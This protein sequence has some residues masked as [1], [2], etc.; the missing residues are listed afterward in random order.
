MFLVHSDELPPDLVA[1][2]SLRDLAP[3]ELL[4]RRGDPAQAVYAVLHGL[5]QLFSCTTEGKQVPLYVAR[6]GECVSEA[7]LFGEVYCSDAMA[8][9]Q[10]RVRAFP[11]KALQNT[12]REHPKLAAEFMALQAERFNWIRS[13]LELRALRSARERILQYLRISSSAGPQ[14]V[15]VDRP[16]KRIAEDLSL[17]PETFYRTLTQLVD[18]GL[19]RRTK[20]TLSLQKRVICSY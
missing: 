6:S 1:T 8:E 3:G 18:E 15:R 14:A 11:K 17:S 12:L 16:L 5:M 9:V 13:S 2:A 4:Y 10:S 20:G 19:V 7:A